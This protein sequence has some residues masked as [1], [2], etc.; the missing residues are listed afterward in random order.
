MKPKKQWL[1]GVVLLLILP[2]I[3]SACQAKRSTAPVIKRPYQKSEFIMGT[4]CTL[5]I[6]NKG[7]KAVLDKGFARIHKSD[8]QASLTKKNTELDKIN[9]NAGIRPVKVSADMWPMVEK[10]MYYSKNSAGAFDMSIGAITNLWKIGL[11]GARVPS[12]GEIDQA[13]PLVD[14]HDVQLNARK[15]TVYLTKKGMRLDFGGIAKGYI[16]DQVRE[17]FKKNGITTAVI[18]LGGNIVVMGHSPVG[19]DKPWN[20]GV[21]NPL[22]ARGKA[23]GVIPEKNVSIVTA[24]IYEQYLKVNGHRYIY[25]MDM[26]T[27]YPYE[28]NLAG[29]TIVSPK[30][31]DGDALSN[32]AFNKGV[33][34]GLAY[35]NNKHKQNIQAIF[36]TKDK[37]IYLTN[38]LKKK[39]KLNTGNGYRL[40]DPTKLTGNE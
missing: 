3:L 11:P 17:V 14:Y 36:V 16:A 29:V 28:N 32:A 25:L 12:R 38:G 33:K 5:S 20:V 13:L 1:L 40:G 10:A 34:G 22:A 23:L 37:Q 2:L 4:I 6:Y 15:R 39:F 18:N 8:N 24:G 19:K 7:K 26:N 30:S 27:G 31:V 35:I 21:Q 9:Q